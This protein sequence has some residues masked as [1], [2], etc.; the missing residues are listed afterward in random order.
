MPALFLPAFPHPTTTA[1]KYQEKILLLK[2]TENGELT[3]L[4]DSVI[5]EI[6]S[7]ITFNAVLSYY[8]ISNAFYDKE[9]DEWYGK[10]PRTINETF[11]A[12]VVCLAKFNYNFYDDYFEFNE[13]T[14]FEVEQIEEV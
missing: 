3:H 6:N 2:R 5:F 1:V 10:Q 9:D 12:K 13:I 8:E 4:D 11:S 7:T 14:F